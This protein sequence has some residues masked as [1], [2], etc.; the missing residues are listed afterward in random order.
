M[1]VSLNLDRMK[2]SNE[3]ETER[4]TEGMYDSNSGED[5]E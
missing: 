5:D 1:S 4:K 2:W 3:N